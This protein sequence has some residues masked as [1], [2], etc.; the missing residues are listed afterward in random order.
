MKR[1]CLGFMVS[2]CMQHV[3][4]IKKDTDKPEQS[5]QN[6]LLNGVGGGLE[7]GENSLNAMVREFKEETGIE[8]HEWNFCGEVTD[9]A[10][11]TISCYIA[12]APLDVLKRVS[13]QPDEKEIP[14]VYYLPLVRSQWYKLANDVKEILEN[15]LWVWNHEQ[16]KRFRQFVM[17][18][19]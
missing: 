15:C 1:Y 19:D 9:K 6:G 10:L 14:G 17:L 8:H 2:T 18:T 11:Y 3:V 13:K 7:A 4:L 5:W 16:Q 12:I